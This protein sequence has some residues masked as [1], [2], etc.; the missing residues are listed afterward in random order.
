AAATFQLGWHGPQFTTKR[1]AFAGEPFRCPT[2][3]PADGE[4]GT[5]D[6]VV[7]EL[8]AAIK[9]AAVEIIFGLDPQTDG[10][11]ERNAHAETADAAPVRGALVVIRDVF[12]AP[13]DRRTTADENA[14][15][16]GSRRKAQHQLGATDEHLRVAIAVD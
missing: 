12:A 6:K 2:P 3:L 16:R 15:P 5:Q 13:N 8:A 9:V 10:R 7:L 11:G 1:P 14:Q 4:A